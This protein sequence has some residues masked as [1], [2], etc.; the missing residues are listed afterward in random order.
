MSMTVT[1]RMTVNMMICRWAAEMTGHRYGL[2]WGVFGISY[3]RALPLHKMCGRFAY[4]TMLIHAAITIHMVM[5]LTILLLT[6]RFDFPPMYVPYPLF[7]G[8]YRCA[9]SL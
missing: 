7:P 2:M 6:R 8:I 5:L 9:L 4:F 3:E 1:M